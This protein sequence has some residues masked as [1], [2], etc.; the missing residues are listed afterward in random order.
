MAEMIALLDELEPQSR[1]ALDGHQQKRAEGRATLRRVVALMKAAG[2]RKLLERWQDPA[3]TSFN[4]TLSN[5]VVKYQAFHILPIKEE[6]HP[7][8]AKTRQA[9]STELSGATRRYEEARS[10]YRALR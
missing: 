4:V 7:F 5:A 9:A 2:G 1:A 6:P 8:A 10:I 3:L